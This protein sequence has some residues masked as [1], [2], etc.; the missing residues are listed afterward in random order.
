MLSLNQAKNGTTIVFRNEPHRVLEAQHLKVGRGGAKL[1]AKLKNLSSG[2]VIEYTFQGDERLEEANVY[3]KKAQYLYSEA[4]T[5]NFMIA[6]TYEQVSVNLDSSHTKFLKEGQEVDLAF[7]NETPI[8][9]RQPKKVELKVEYTE[10]ATKG[11]TVTAATK[12]ATLETGA[13]IQVPLFVNSGD[14][15]LV[16]TENAS[17]D[18]RVSK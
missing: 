14:V 3:Y 18:S 17:Y 6:D 13:V 15:L 10:P 4:A 2:A 9:V 16:N 7:W 11:N 5:G 1:V 12:P 8:E